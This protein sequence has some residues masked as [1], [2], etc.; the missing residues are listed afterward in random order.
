MKVSV[1]M[2]KISKLIN[3]PIDLVEEIERYQKENYI[4]SFTG[5]IIELIRKGLK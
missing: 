4:N 3:F 1:F 2:K 5:A